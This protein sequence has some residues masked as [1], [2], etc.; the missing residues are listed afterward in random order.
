MLKDELNALD[1]ATAVYEAQFQRLAKEHLRDYVESLTTAMSGFGPD[2]YVCPCCKSGSGN[3]RHFTPG[4]HLFRHH[5]GNMHFK[6]H[7][8]GVTG[9][10]FDLAGLITGKDSFPEQQKAVAAFLGVD[11]ARRSPLSEIE[12]KA[13]PKP[14]DHVDPLQLKREARDYIVAC[15]EHV[16]E[17]AF[18]HKRGLTDETIRRFGLGFDPQTRRAIIPFGGSYYVARRVDVGADE[19][20]RRKHY[21]PKGLRQPL[22]NPGCLSDRSDQAVFIV[23]AP[24]D[25]ISI[26]QCGGDAIALGGCSTTAF[27]KVLD[28]YRPQCHFVLAF[29]CDAPGQRAQETVRNMIDS[30]GLSCSSPL[31]PAFAR[32]KDA[33]AILMSEPN[34]LREAIRQER[35]RLAFKLERKRSA[36]ERTEEIVR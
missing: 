34:A 20:A 17:T 14:A 32:H 18:F 23:E 35:D 25:A 36:G 26:M 4:F 1:R 27:E 29:D 13:T 16:N 15:K 10:I 30:R 31:H 9:D 24:L 5:S 22:F 21:K 12:P 33:N 2:F 6:C 19:K 8:C 28:V 11:L 3:N 7:A